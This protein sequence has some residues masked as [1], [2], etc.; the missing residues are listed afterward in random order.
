MFVC[1]YVCYALPQ[2]LTTNTSKTYKINLEIRI[3]GVLNEK[4]VIC[5]CREWLVS[6]VFYKEGVLF[7]ILNNIDLVGN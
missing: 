2:I 3:P 5:L 6:T 1:S 7:D 4:N